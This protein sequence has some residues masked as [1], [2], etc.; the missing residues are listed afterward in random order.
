MDQGIRKLITMHKVFFSRDD[1]DGVYGSRRDAGRGFV[2]IEDSIDST[3]RGLENY[4]EK[5]EKRL[6]SVTIS[7]TDNVR[8]NQTKITKKQKWEEKQL[9][10][11]FKQQ[12][13]EISHEKICT[14][15]TKGNVKKETKSLL[16]AA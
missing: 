6:I 5:R 2:N 8:T 9:Y 14:G 3:M 11:Y 1:K 7:S 12:T 15:L 10:G 16:I 4:N 13:V